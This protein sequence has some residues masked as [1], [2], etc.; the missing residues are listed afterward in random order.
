[1]QRD[2]GGRSPIDI[3]AFLNHKN[4]LLYMLTNH[5]T[6]AMFVDIDLKLDNY[7]RTM[8]HLMGYRGTLDCL[9]VSLNY[10]RI[11]I[12][13]VYTDKLVEIKKRY[14]M[15]SLE[16]LKGKLVSTVHHNHATIRR[17]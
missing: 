17:H 7:E 3:A 11:C 4:T 2:R 16:I 12:K 14:S 1:M 5:G 6:P 10:D 13:K 8:Y 15:K 9:I